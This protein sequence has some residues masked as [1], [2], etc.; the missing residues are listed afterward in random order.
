MGLE[1]LHY[2]MA[3]EHIRISLYKSISIARYTTL[4]VATLL[5]YFLVRK[6]VQEKLILTRLTQKQCI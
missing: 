4:Y 6:L 2:K 1:D 5:H 3:T